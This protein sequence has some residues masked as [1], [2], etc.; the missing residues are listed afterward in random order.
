MENRPP[1]VLACEAGGFNVD[2]KMLDCCWGCEVEELP[3]RVEPVCAEL[4]AP[5]LPN[6]DPDVDAG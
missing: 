1:D 4:V 6:S 3:N 5:K 2:P